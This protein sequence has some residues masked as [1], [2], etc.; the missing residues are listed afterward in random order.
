MFTDKL[1]FTCNDATLGLEVQ[2]PTI[3]TDDIC[4]QFKNIDF[5]RLPTKNYD[6]SK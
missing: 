3:G 5:Y 4:I 2:Q 6:S 1:T